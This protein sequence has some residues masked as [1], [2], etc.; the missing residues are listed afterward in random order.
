MSARTRAVETA[1][2]N[3]ALRE[4]A[5]LSVAALD[6]LDSDGL[7]AVAVAWWQRLD[8]LAK[9]APLDAERIVWAM[10]AHLARYQP[11]SVVPLDE[12]FSP[13]EPVRDPRAKR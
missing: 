2:D 8:A 3:G 9:V 4:L 6:D 11:A 7:S 10:K 5:V 1:S 13:T 12:G